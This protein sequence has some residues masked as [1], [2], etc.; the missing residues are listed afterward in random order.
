VEFSFR[1][2]FGGFD[3]ENLGEIEMIA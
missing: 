1:L 2:Y 3:Q